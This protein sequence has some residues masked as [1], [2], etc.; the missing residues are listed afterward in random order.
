MVASARWCMWLVQLPLTWPLESFD[1]DVRLCFSNCIATD[2]SDATWKQAQ[3][4]LRYGGLGLHSILY[5][6][7]A[8]YITSLSFTGLGSADNPHLVRSIVRYNGLVSPPDSISVES[9][10]LPQSHREFCLRGWMTTPL[11]L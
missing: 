6:S 1:S 8:A 2:I 5:H 7:C 11:G 4:G 10:W 3:L 9:I